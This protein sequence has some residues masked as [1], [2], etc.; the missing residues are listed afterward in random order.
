VIVLL[1]APRLRNTVK[2]LYIRLCDFCENNH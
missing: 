1:A 2:E